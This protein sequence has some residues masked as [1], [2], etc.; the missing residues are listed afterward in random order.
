MEVSAFAVP[1]AVRLLHAVS[2]ALTG[3]L[4]RL[5]GK[6][7]A[8]RTH[9]AYRSGW[10]SYVRACEHIGLNPAPATETKLLAFIAHAH[11]FFHLR[12]TTICNYLSAICYVHKISG[13][14]TPRRG[15]SLL[16][17]ALDGCARSDKEAGK[18]P[19]VR[20]PVTGA[21][22]AR[23]ISSL[24][25]LQFSDCRFACYASLSYFGA[26][27]AGDLLRQQRNGRLTWDDVRFF[28]SMQ[29][30][31]FCI[32]NVRMDKINQVGPSVAVTIPATGSL[33]CPVRLLLLYMSFFPERHSD[34]SVFSPTAELSYSYAKALLETRQRL[35]AIGV[36]GRLFGCHSYRI[37][38]ATVA[39]RRGL[40]DWAVKTLGRWNS[41]CY[42][43]YIRMEADL[44]ASL[45]ATL[46]DDEDT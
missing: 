9:S 30:P 26:F 21:L 45:S 7:R 11:E 34:G 1:R 20:L 13:M 10:R 43:R 41:A 14:N 35:R 23:L 5:I 36:D 42:Q 37:G 16:G 24:D 15:G 44:V 32:L 2:P 38:A 4:H 18:E 29:A 12:A 33:T 3:V 8:K 39:A 28:P 22:L 40:P 46:A 19:R 6:A 27:R 31:Q 25:L 17:L